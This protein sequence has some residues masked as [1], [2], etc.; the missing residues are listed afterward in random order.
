MRKLADL[1]VSKFGSS[2]A[3]LSEKEEYLSERR[4][5]SEEEVP[6]KQ[7]RLVVLTAVRSQELCL[8]RE[9]INLG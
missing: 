3:F 2:Q 7:W 6:C 9:K 1:P 8:D 5:W 4:S